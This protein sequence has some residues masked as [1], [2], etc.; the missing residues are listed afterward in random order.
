[1]TAKV[2]VGHLLAPSG[3]NS[4]ETMKEKNENRLDRTEIVPL[5][6]ASYGLHQFLSEAHF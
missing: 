1:M 3:P 2:C 6:I 5:V 4:L